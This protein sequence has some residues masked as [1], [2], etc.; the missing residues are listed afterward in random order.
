M[1]NSRK[2]LAIIPARSGSKG[3]IDKNIREINGLPLLA[4]P[5]IAAKGSKYIDYI[6]FT[7]D[8]KKYIDIAKMY[9]AQ[10]PFKRPP[11]LSSD[12]SN[13][14]D[15]IL[16]ALNFME[17]RLNLTFDALIYLEPTSPLTTS[18]DIDESLEYFYQENLQSLVSISESHTHHPE[19][20]V[21]FKNDSS[22][23]KP[24]LKENFKDLIINR[25]GLTPVYFFDG[26]LYISTTKSFKKEKEFYHENTHGII[27]NGNK[28]PE[29]DEEVD[30][31]IVELFLN[32]K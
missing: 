7:S 30:F 8:S 15:V 17:D 10:A 23:I 26:S 5:I 6:L 4:Y 9:G 28:S 24:F 2:T 32:Q 14:S 25:Q 13:R 31:K 20:S 22:L 19:Y 12:N 16:H 29:I 27:L 11:E 1:P 3:V 18:Q 21:V